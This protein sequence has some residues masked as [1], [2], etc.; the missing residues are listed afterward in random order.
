MLAGGGVAFEGG[1]VLVRGGM[2]VVGPG[3][4]PTA[5]VTAA[6]SSRSLV[7]TEVLVA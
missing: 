5:E 6:L 1:L 3:K 2:Q 4:I 7:D